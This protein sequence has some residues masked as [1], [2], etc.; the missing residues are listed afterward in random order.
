MLITWVAG[1]IVFAPVEFCREKIQSFPSPFSARLFRSSSKTIEKKSD[2]VTE[3][4][5]LKLYEI[6][7][8]IMIE[9]DEK[10]LLAKLKISLLV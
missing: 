8:Q 9:Q 4:R 6:G 10:Y 2:D 1:G 5:F 7:W 3:T